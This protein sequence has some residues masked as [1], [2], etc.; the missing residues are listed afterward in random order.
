MLCPFFLFRLE[1]L[2]DLPMDYCMRDTMYTRYTDFDWCRIGVGGSCT[3]EKVK[4]IYL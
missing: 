4:I 1:L 3:K 2:K